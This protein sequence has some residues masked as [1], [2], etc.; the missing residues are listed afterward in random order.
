MSKHPGWGLIPQGHTPTSGRCQVCQSL[1][2][3]WRR[4]GVGVQ[5]T[6]AE[7]KLPPPSSLQNPQISH[8]PKMVFLFF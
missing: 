4:M 6:T 2:P 8:W 3:G 7:I 5:V 1:S